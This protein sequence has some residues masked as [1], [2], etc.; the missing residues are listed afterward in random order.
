MS[1]KD[2]KKLIQEE[3]SK[4]KKPLRL[5]FSVGVRVDEEIRKLSNGEEVID[6]QTKLPISKEK[7]IY[8]K[9]MLFGQNPDKFLQLFPGENDFFLYGYMKNYV[10]YCK[11][12]EEY[13]NEGGYTLN[14]NYANPA[15]AEQ[16]KK[17]EKLEG[18]RLVALSNCEKEDV[19]SF[20][21]KNR[22]GDPTIELFY[23][24]KEIE[25]D[26]YDIIMKTLPSWFNVD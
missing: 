15:N 13:L 6:R 2:Y 19:G 25:E 9:S 5:G 7:K 21:F 16:I 8:L 1:D 23:F 11:E 26:N 12:N 4:I 14:H 3:R 10:R 24:L 22:E 17:D 18:L 20:L